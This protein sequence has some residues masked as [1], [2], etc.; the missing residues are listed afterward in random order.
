MQDSILSK[1]RNPAR[2]QIEQRAL[3][4]FEWRRNRNDI[5][6]C[7]RN[8]QRLTK[9]EYDTRGPFLGH[10]NIMFEKFP[11]DNAGLTPTYS[12]TNPLKDRDIHHQSVEIYKPKLPRGRCL[13]KAMIMETTRTSQSIDDKPSLEILSAITL[14]QTA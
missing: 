1:E 14:K 8:I 13:A 10:Q 2:P 7:R 4:T 5:N 9:E 11:L 3:Q 6:V 12:Y